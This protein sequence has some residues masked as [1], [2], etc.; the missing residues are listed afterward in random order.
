M[1]G[2]YLACDLGAESGRLIL[3][4]IDDNRLRLEEIHRFSNRPIR[5]GNSL[6]WNIEALFSE[7]KH[8]LAKAAA[9]RVPV[10]SISTDSWGVDYVLFDQAG[11][12]I[13]RISAPGR[14]HS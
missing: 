4:V 5:A 8:G 3:G 2:H 10:A 9:K 14:G 11:R 12:I 7:L 6:Q 13:G 1:P